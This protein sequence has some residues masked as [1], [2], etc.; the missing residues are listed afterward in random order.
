MLHFAV[1]DNRQAIMAFEEDQVRGI[2]RGPYVY[3][4]QA[5]AYAELG[6]KNSARALIP[7]LN[8]DLISQAFP[9]EHWL[10]GMFTDEQRLQGTLSILYRMGMLR[11]EQRLQASASDGAQPSPGKTMD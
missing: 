2:R 3:A 9:V 5:A 6:E 11:P 4:L 7:A 8:E 1:G 10:G